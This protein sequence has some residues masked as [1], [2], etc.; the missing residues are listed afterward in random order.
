MSGK[1]FA[2]D[3]VLHQWRSGILKGIMSTYHQAIWDIL[4]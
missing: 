4:L 2:S 3:I 1:I